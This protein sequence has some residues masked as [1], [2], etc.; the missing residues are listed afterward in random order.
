MIQVFLRYT[1]YTQCQTTA[2]LLKQGSFQTSLTNLKVLKII[3]SGFKQ[4]ISQNSRP[5]RWNQATET[6]MQENCGHRKKSDA[7][8][9]PS[10]EFW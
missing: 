5:L 1:K 10:N 7:A 6:I 8:D 9:F 2:D 3:L 4:D